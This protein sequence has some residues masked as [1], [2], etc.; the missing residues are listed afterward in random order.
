MIPLFQPLLYSF[1][2][3]AAL[4]KF[5]FQEKRNQLPAKFVIPLKTSLSTKRLNVV[6]GDGG[7]A[8]SVK[9]TS[10]TLIP[11]FAPSLVPPPP[12]CITNESDVVYVHHMISA[13]QTLGKCIANIP[14]PYNIPTFYN[15]AFNDI[16]KLYTNIQV[17]NLQ[18]VK[19]LAYM[20]F[21]KY[22]KV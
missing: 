14:D 8:I 13:T 12:N 16:M 5:S 4:G 6:H 7:N 22:S 17:N 11:T 2:L 18:E 1:L 15:G 21:D 9:A 3:I 19:N 10:P 20:L